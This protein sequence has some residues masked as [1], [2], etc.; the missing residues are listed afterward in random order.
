MLLVASESRGCFTSSALAP[1]ERGQEQE[2]LGRMGLLIHDTMQGIDTRGMGG[3][4]WAQLGGDDDMLHNG[5]CSSSLRGS[6]L[7]LAYGLLSN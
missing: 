1:R 3:M 5:H 2:R 6:S 7:T 4:A